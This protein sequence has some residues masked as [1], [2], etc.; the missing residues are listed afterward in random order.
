MRHVEGLL[1]LA[2]LV[3]CGDL[4]HEPRS[5]ATS[6]DAGTG[7][8]AGQLDAQQEPEHQLV[9][10]EAGS[11]ADAAEASQ[12]SGQDA[13][14]AM[15]PDA[16]AGAEADA[17]WGDVEAGEGDAYSE[18]GSDAP[19]SYDPCSPPSPVVINCN[20]LCG[21]TTPAIDGGWLC[22]SG[23]ECLVPNV[24]I[25]P[26]EAD[27][28]VELPSVTL[29]HPDICQHTCGGYT[30]ALFEIKAQTGCVTVTTN[31]SRGLVL[32]GDPMPCSFPYE[33]TSMSTGPGK[34]IRV[35]SAHMS[36]PAWVRVQWSQQPCQ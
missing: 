9:N 8:D 29:V 36:G 4:N 11:E 3:G 19:I 20:P 23:A 14:E 21:A 32:D 2:L 22:S 34:S 15:A 12:D 1:V 6:T 26:W 24:V 28:S 27:L 33:T 31:G 10:P 18:P 17:A 16:E 7:A 35:I 25:V 5:L 30:S 13:A